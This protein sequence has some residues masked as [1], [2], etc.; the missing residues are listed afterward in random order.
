VRDARLRAAQ[1][2]V[3]QKSNHVDD[4]D[5]RSDKDVPELTTLDKQNDSND[6]SPSSQ[7]GVGKVAEDVDVPLVPVSQE[8][9]SVRP[10]H[11][12]YQY[13]RTDVGRHGIANQRR[14]DRLEKAINSA[15]VIEE[16]LP[17][18]KDQMEDI[19]VERISLNPRDIEAYERLGDYYL[20]QKNL[21]D[22]KECYRQVLKLSPA[23]RLVKIKIRR[24]ERLLEKGGVV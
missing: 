1:L 10:S 18:K 20:E 6:N 19:L 16:A 11:Q 2:R 8:S 12:K 5:E 7:G 21:I 14:F 24:L 23:Y 9:D 3:D 15:R 4:I 22:A 13:R 17:M